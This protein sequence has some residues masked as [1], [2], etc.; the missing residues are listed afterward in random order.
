[1]I[2]DK[3]MALAT[4]HPRGTERRRLAPYRAA[5]NDVGAYAA[6]PE[7]D[8]DVIVRWAEIRRRLRDEHGIDHDPANFADTLLEA[9]RLIE[10]VLAGER[11]LAGASGGRSPGDVIAAVAAVRRG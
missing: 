3:E 5:L 11:R 1:M 2:D 8:R 10:W 7:G 4:E 9:K 6:L